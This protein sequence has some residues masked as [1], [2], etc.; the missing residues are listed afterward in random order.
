[1]YPIAAP[2]TRDHGG[3]RTALRK[4]NESGARSAVLPQHDAHVPR[5]AEGGRLPHSDR[6]R[7][8]P[9]T[10]EKPHGAVRRAAAREHDDR[11]AEKGS[12][13]SSRKDLLASSSAFARAEKSRL[14]RRHSFDSI[15][16]YKPTQ[17]LKTKKKQQYETSAAPSRPVLYDGPRG[18][19][20]A[21]TAEHATTHCV[22]VPTSIS[23]SLADIQSV[24]GSSKGKLKQA[25]APASGQAIRSDSRKSRQAAVVQPS[26]AGRSTVSRTSTVPY[27]Q[28]R[29]PARDDSI[30]FDFDDFY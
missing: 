8:T 26:T 29:W 21:P 3:V 11:T 13:S 14:Q 5:P 1:M 10:I 9:N 7:V 24:D 25:A 16:D 6:P 18:L 30:T 23:F 19:M 27:A 12:L 4:T 20:R 22:E 2:K 17:G 15:V 28:A